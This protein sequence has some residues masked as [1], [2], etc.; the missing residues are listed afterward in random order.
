MSECVGGAAREGA[1]PGDV[2]T[3]GVDE[4]CPY[5]IPKRSETITDVDTG[6]HRDANSPHRARRSAT[7]TPP[8]TGGGHPPVLAGHDTLAVMPT[9][10]GKSAIYQIAGACSCRGPTVVV[11]PL[12]ALQRDQV[13]AI[14]ARTTS[15][16][17]RDGQLDA[18]R[19]GAAGGVRR[20]RGR[21][22][23]GVPVPGP[24]AVCQPGRCSSGSAAHAVAVRRGR[25][26]LR[27]RVG[28]RLPAR[29]PAPG[30]GGRGARPPDRPG[31]DRDGR[32]AGAR[33]DRRAAGDARAAGR[34]ARAST[35]RTSGWA[36]SASPTRRQ[37][38]APCSSARS[39]RPSPASST[40][41][42][43]STPRR[44]RSELRERGVT[45]ACLPRRAEDGRARGGA[46]GFM[47]DELR[48]D[49]GDHRVRHGHRQARRA[50]RLP[51][52]RQRLAS[53]P[54]TRRSAA[55]A[56]T[57]SRRGR[58]LFY[59]P[60]DLGLRRF[61]AGGGRW[62]ASRSSR[63]RAVRAPCGPVEPRELRRGDGLS[64]VEAGDGAGRLEEVGAVEVLPTARWW[65]RR[66]RRPRHRRRREAARPRHTTRVRASRIEM[67][68][69]YAESGRLS[70]PLPAQLLRRGVWPPAALRQCQ[71]GRGGRRTDRPATPSH[72]NSR[73]AH[74]R[75]GARGL[76]LRYE[77]TRRLSSC[78]TP[79]ATSH[80]RCLSCGNA[81]C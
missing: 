71:G 73:V 69:G 27:Q 9:G 7:A 45:A 77:G 13:E 30:R 10:S 63:W 37:D 78:S 39:R 75:T 18:A 22:A 3:P 17:R 72:S 25:G 50:L 28:P 8:R 49:R 5:Q 65:L 70:P 33:R 56:G 61:F 34:R 55:P 42:R 1:L 20:A 44:S 80:W 62:D 40:P 32:A 67:M 14:D 46:G 68:R 43:I 52:R 51:P 48:G 29:L 66:R 19:G 24:R 38:A 35:G 59:R 64:R 31:A 23:S 26:S 57:A 74:T 58:M 54:T 53:T 60:E 36:S 21:R 16:Q 79:T 41:R 81:A 4:V 76:V 2:G 15:A 12:I 47:D 6:D 11:S